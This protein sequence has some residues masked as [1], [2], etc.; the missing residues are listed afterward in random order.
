[1]TDAEGKYTLQIN[2]DSEILVFSFL[3][4]IT[5]RIEAGKRT[6]LDVKLLPNPAKRFLK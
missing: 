3:G 5:Q 6:T 4:F 2:N 1:M